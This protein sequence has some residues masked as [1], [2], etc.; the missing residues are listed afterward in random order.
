MC[1]SQIVRLTDRQADRH[2]VNLLVIPGVIAF[3]ECKKK[4]DSYTQFC[5]HPTTC[6]YIK[7]VFNTEMLVDELGNYLD[8]I[9]YTKDL[10]TAL[11]GAKQ[12][13]F[14]S[15]SPTNNSFRQLN[16]TVQDRSHG[17]KR[18]CLA[19]TSIQG[20][21]SASSWDPQAITEVTK[22]QL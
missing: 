18:H 5:C 4:N 12:F 22:I 3:K 14:G 13:L 8:R 11:H 10:H 15:K 9:G 7:V 6:E 20:V 16:N 21:A 19:G 1:V 17:S 2:T